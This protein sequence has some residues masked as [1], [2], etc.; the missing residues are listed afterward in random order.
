MALYSFRRWVDHYHISLLNAATGLTWARDSRQPG[1][2]MSVPKYG[3][4]STGAPG[5]QV[6]PGVQ[7]DGVTELRVH[8]VGGT[9]PGALLNDLAPGQVAGDSTA[10]FYRTADLLSPSGTVSRHVEGYS[11]GGLTSRSSWR[12]FWLLLLP[13]LLGNLAGW[14]CSERTKKD[15]ASSWRFRVHRASAGLACLALTINLV[16][17]TAMITA[18]VVAYQAVRAG[19]ANGRWWLAPLRWPAILGHP[20]RQVLLGMIVPAL[21]IVLLELLAARSRSR[22]E[23]V[24][25]PYRGAKRP[26]RALTV[27]AALDK[28][29]SDRQFWDG[30]HSVWHSAIRHM[31]AS[32]GFVALMLSITSR[33]A[34]TAVHSNVS[35][36]GLWWAALIG[37]GAVVAFVII[38][39][40]FDFRNRASRFSDSFAWRFDHWSAIA[41]GS[42]AI[43]AMVCAGTFA[44]LQPPVTAVAGQ[45]PGMAGILGWTMTAAAVTIGL[46][47]LSSAVGG[48][49]RGT[50]FMG[51]FVTLILA[52]SLLN[53]TMFGG[54]LSLAHLLGNLTFATPPHASQ[55]YLPGLIG[56]GTPALVIATLLTVALF[57]VVEFIIWRRAGGGHVKKE[58]EG[59][60][61]VSPDVSQ[62]RSTGQPAPEGL[63][64]WEIS[65]LD[66][67]KSDGQPHEGKK[68]AGSIAR[69]QRI[70]RASRDA[71]WLLWAL[72]LFEIA[73]A[74][75]TVT[76]QPSIA[77]DTWYAPDRWYGKAAITVATFLPLFLIGL[78]RSGWGQPDRRR[79]IGVLWDVGTFW[80]RSYHPLAPP[81]Y[82][83]R[84]VPD[85][86]RRLWWIHDNN[87]RVLLVGHSQ[88]SVLAAAALLQ[89]DCLPSND[90]TA[91]VTFGCPLGKLYSWGF[92]AYVNESMLAGLV[93][94]GDPGWANFYYPTDPIGGPV[95]YDSNPAQ[96]N[97]QP[98]AGQ[99]LQKNQVDVYLLDPAGY[100]YN[101]GQPKPAPGGHSGYWTDPRVWE[102][103]EK[104]GNGP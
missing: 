53:V 4:V 17:V 25:P 67:P 94:K 91:L 73:A 43:V 97:V 29:L 100:A 33:N 20:G 70:G 36:V 101:Y 34:V 11:W 8:G 41:Q 62:A 72:A 16:L 13:F 64:L 40:C 65:A 31:T 98:P 84:A 58:I 52:F 89:P 60:Y 66:P 80:P 63:A 93:N 90:Q 2:T 87:G 103:F 6:P 86:Q 48:R 1:G 7:L 68:W 95:F 39:T 54:M 83:E 12:V 61:G 10:G 19:A 35:W 78:L 82:A 71:G 21:V 38:R 5:G 102:Q 69:T 79:R 44:W 57:A 81:C 88:G 56:L 50:V 85:L 28:G 27:A 59:Q 92:P 14:M 96:G 37:S 47:L 26:P 76:L 9:P 46:V 24:P 30:E 18:D 75:A 23:Q 55:I 99:Q 49:T 77:L 51:P 45:L 22:Y 74:V 15:G 104:F 42:I 32:F 3:L